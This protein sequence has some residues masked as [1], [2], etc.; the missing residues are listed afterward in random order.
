MK[1]VYL[2]RSI[3][4][5]KKTYIGITEDLNTRLT[6][7][8]S[9]KSHHTSRHTPWEIEVAIRF[10]DE[11]RAVAFGRYLKFGSGHASPN[12]TTNC[13]GHASGNNSL[14]GAF[15]ERHAMPGSRSSNL[16]GSTA[17]SQ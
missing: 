6:E 9:G 1:Y 12:G 17:P 10:Q 8:N 5:P 7:H 16:G 15:N 4:N 3:S 11:A 14:S 2:L 13:E